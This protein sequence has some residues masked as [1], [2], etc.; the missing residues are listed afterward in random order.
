MAIDEALL[1]SFDPATSLPLLRLYGWQPPAISLGRFQDAAR[2]LNLD[3]CHTAGVPVVRRITGGGVIYHADELTYSIVCAPH[4]LPSATS[5]ND[6]FRLLTSFLLIFYTHLGLAPRY[7]ADVCPDQQLGQRTPFCFAGKESYDILVKGKKIGGNAQRRLKEVVFQHGS[8]PLKNRA[9]EGGSFMR[10]RPLDL[11]EQTSSL[12]E[13]CI[14]EAETKLKSLLAESFRE[15]MGVELQENR[16][17]TEEETKSVELLRKYR[18]DGWNI[19]G[20]YL[21]PQPP[22]TPSESGRGF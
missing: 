10:E 7:A 18:D 9:E 11:Q 5:I 16:L 13:S 17:T 15:G 19:Q 14:G 8:I 3:R 1:L 4:H 2:V 21:I 22:L 20:T 6:S 12:A